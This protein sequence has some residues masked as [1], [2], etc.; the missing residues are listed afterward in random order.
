V[1]R[2]RVWGLT[3]PDDRKNEAG[4]C[5][6]SELFSRSFLTANPF[7][8][9]SEEQSDEPDEKTDCKTA[10]RYTGPERSDETV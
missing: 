10:P 7:F 6:R 2:K 4:K 1:R 8:R 3:G 5:E 9:P